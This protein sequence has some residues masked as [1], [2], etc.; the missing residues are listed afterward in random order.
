[1][2]DRRR[3]LRMMG[4]GTCRPAAASTAVAM[5]D[6]CE[7]VSRLVC[8]S[9]HLQMVHGCCN[10]MAH[11]AWVA[12]QFDNDTFGLGEFVHFAP[13]SCM[14][15]SPVGANAKTRMPHFSSLDNLG[16]CVQPYQI[17]QSNFSCF[18]RV[19]SSWLTSCFS[20]HPLGRRQVARKNGIA[21]LVVLRRVMRK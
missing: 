15:S 20:F 2:R 4:L 19:G 14:Y 17:Q 5:S 6:E 9:N 21:A 12:I 10:S 18:F 13:L 1:M 11:G 8:T 7:I 16:G 3:L